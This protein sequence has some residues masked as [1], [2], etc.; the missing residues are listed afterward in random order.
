MAVP[1]LGQLLR[2]IISRYYSRLKLL[3]GPQ[4]FAYKTVPLPRIAHS[5]ALRI[6]LVVAPP[7]Q[8]AD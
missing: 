1:L 5:L 4:L 8:E 3:Q 6:G 2:I 7:E